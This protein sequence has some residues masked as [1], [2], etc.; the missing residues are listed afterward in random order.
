MSQQRG[1]GAWRWASPW[2][3]SDLSPCPPPP[4]L[5]PIANPTRLLLRAKH[6]GRQ[7]CP[8]ERRP[9]GRSAF[10]PFTVSRAPVV[11]VVVHT[12]PMPPF[13]SRFRTDAGHHGDPARGGGGPLRLH[14]HH[15]RP[16]HAAFQR[17]ADGQARPPTACP[18]CARAAPADDRLGPGPARQLP[19]RPPAT[20]ASLRWFAACVG[21]C[22]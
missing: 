6:G 21:R 7:L 5:D 2:A 12:L 14:Q 9:I 1:H 17:G 20:T 16:L 4:S 10:L 22:A 19:P 13:P 18:A 11:V 15:L 3:C 8:P